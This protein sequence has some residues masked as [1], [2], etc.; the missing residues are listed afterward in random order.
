M[1]EAKLEA[2]QRGEPA[3]VYTGGTRRVY[4]LVIGFTQK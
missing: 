3:R 2:R 1:I 4:V